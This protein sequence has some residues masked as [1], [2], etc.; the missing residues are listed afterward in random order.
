MLDLGILDQ[1]KARMIITFEV[2]LNFGLFQF[3][4]STI[5]TILSYLLKI[6][7]NP[8]RNFV[9]HHKTPHK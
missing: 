5:D 8:F 3:T 9:E 6:V 4:S 1:A 7:E 2:H